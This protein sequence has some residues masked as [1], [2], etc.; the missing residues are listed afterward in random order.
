[1]AEKLSITIALEGGKAIEQQLEGI[2]KAGQKAFEDISKAAEQAGGFKNLKPEEVTAKLKDMGVVGKEALDGIAEAVK[3][4]TRLER[5]VGIVQGLETGFAGLATA[6]GLFVRALGPIAAAGVAIGG[7]LV[8]NMDS[9]A[10]AINKADAAAIKLGLSIEKFD[11]LRAGFE[12]IGASAGAIGDGIAHVQSEIEK[13]NIEKV[14]KSF[15]ELEEAAKR[16][17]GGIGTEQFNFLIEMA[18]RT[19]KAADAA[20]AALEKLGATVFAPAAT[21]ALTRLGIAA[22]TASEVIPQFVERMRLLPDSAQRTADAIAVLGPKLGVEFVQAL[23]T[24]GVAVDTFRDNLRGLTQDQANAANLWEQNSNKLTASW[25]RFKTSIGADLLVTNSMRELNSLL[26]AMNTLLNA[27]AAQWKQAFFDLVQPI[28]DIIAKIGELSSAIGGG[29]WDTFAS[30]GT[31]AIEAITGAI[32]GLLAKMR[33]IGSAI[34]GA[35]SGGGGEAA[36]IPGNASGGLIGGRGSGTS[37]SNLAWVS[38]GEHIMPARAVRQ[39]GVLAL[40]ESLRR[41]GGNLRG[42]LDGMGRFA[43][44]GVVPRFA[45]GGLVGAM[46]HLGTVDLRTDHGAVR[47]MAG[48][49]AVEQLSR[50]AVTKRMTSTGKKPGFIG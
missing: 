26:E 14:K 31:A 44:G 45:E 34:A 36:G 2:G 28:S 1:M 39:P 19:G 42:V 25:E 16:G 10:E 33:A 9:A 18:G 7:A 6:A 49:S 35:F 24:G 47:L 11:Q 38:R 17:F 29:I 3:G 22:T 41:S 30:A 5:V 21:D 40:L 13:I 20:R 43:A 46:G 32:D 23:R 50:L 4:A 15:Q 12:R 48:S 27:S 8:K 37:D